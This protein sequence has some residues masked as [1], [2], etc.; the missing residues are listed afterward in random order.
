M[1]LLTPSAAGGAPQVI[2]HTEDGYSRGDLNNRLRATEDGF[3]FRVNAPALDANAY[4]RNVIYRYQ[5]KT[6]AV[7]RVGPIATTGRGFVEEWLSMPWDEAKNVTAQEAIA[8]MKTIHDR[9]QQEDKDV[10][11]YVG[12]TYGPVRSCTVKGRYEV[13]MD[14]DP[15]GP[16]FYAIQEGKDGYSMVNFGTTQDER[17]SSPDL[18]KS[19]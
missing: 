5:V 18:M 14:A 10:K 7:K 16:Q 12:Y 15:G 17:C 11:T 1:D 19:R 3:E 6:N 9:L 2:W 13:E 4:E 8:G